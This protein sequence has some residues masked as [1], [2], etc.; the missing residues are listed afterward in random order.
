MKELGVYDTWVGGKLMWT[1]IKAKS[2]K[3]AI[4]I[5]KE[6]IEGLHPLNMSDEG[7]EEYRNRFRGHPI[8]VKYKFPAR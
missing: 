8:T 1:C 7:V 2:D 4:D 5:V 6:L 3:E